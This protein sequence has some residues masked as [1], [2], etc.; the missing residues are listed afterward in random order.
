MTWA[1]HYLSGISS[2]ANAGYSEEE[3][4][5]QLKSSKAKAI[6]TC[7]PLL[8]TSIA[9]AAKCGIPKKNI[10]LLPVPQEL[11]GGKPDPPDFE[12]VEQLIANGHKLPRAE[13]LRWSKGQGAK[14][15]AFLCYSSGT[16]GLPVSLSHQQSGQDAF[17]TDRRL[18]AQKGVMISHRNVIANVLQICAF[19]KPFRNLNK[20]SSDGYPKPEV[21]LGLLPQSHI[22][23]L[24]VICHAASYRGDQIINLPKFEM[25]HLL[26]AIQRFKIN[27]LF[28]VPPIIIGMANNPQVLAKFDISS[29]TQIFTGAAPLGAETAETLMKQHPK[30]M[31]RQ[32]Y[33]LTETSTVMTSTAYDDIWLGSCGSI[34]PLVK[35][36]I[37]ST[38]GKEITDYD[39]PGELVVKSPSIVL[40][41]LNN[42]KANKETFVNGWMHTGD[43]AVVRKAPSGN[44]HVFIVDRIKELIKVKVSALPP[45]PDT[46]SPDNYRHIKSHPQSSKRTFSPIHL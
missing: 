4:V 9:A 12:T 5:Y 35:A 1:I 31:I 23:S 19:E 40:G 10:Y 46:Q 32:G 41:Y 38:D 27:T 24:V 44:E 33:G 37:V 28:L 14:Q 39:T 3:L 15:T 34:L 42:E 30:W 6:F 43:E 25:G 26:S 7:L 8:Q 2:P 21:A 36:R 13:A 16:S 17:K 29:V 20:R 22:Y 18:L 45:I 11:T